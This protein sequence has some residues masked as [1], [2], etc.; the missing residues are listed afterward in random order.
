MINRSLTAVALAVAAGGVATANADVVLTLTYHDLNGS[1]TQSSPGVGAFTAVAAGSEAAGEVSR[2]DTNPGN[3][4]FEVGFEVDPNPADFQLSLSVNTIAPGVATGSGSMIL[5]D[6]NGDTIAANLSG[7]WIYDSV[8][9][10]IFFNGAVSNVVVTDNGTL[11]DLFDGTQFGSFQLSG[12]D[13]TDGAL[14]QIV[15]GAGSF[16]ATDFVNAATG[17]TAQIVPAPGALAL[18]GL[19]G[20]VAGRR[21]R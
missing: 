8:N 3:A 12:M 19:G 17:V 20:L 9:G 18:L 2:V 6:A 1:Y 10:F 5:T 16:F 15:F 13:L 14:T 4:S 21:R 11:D 7:A